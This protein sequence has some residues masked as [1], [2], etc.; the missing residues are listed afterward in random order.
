[1]ILG[2][3]GPFHLVVEY[4]E[5]GSLKTYLKQIRIKEPTYVNDDTDFFIEHAA[6]LLSFCWQIS[7]GM[8]YLSDI[9]VSIILSLLL[10]DLPFSLVALVERCWPWA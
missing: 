1:M 3:V 4:C 10:I 2:F 8:Q 6:R 5:H 7:K 9:K